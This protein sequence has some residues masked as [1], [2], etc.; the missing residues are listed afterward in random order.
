VLRKGE[1]QSPLELFRTASDVVAG[2]GL[3]P[4]RR[5]ELTYIIT[6]KEKAQVIAERILSTMARGVTSIEGKGAYTGEEREILLV[7][8]HPEQV[9][10]LKRLVREIDSTAFVIFHHAHEVVGEGFRAPG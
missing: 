4:G 8:I 3:F 6:S 9:V 5:E 2:H 10:P 1:V 7:A